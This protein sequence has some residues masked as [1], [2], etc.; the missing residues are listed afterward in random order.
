MLRMQ[1]GR[2]RIVSSLSGPWS[3]FG[4]AEFRLVPYGVVS[5]TKAA[6]R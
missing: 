4:C 2:R 1:K 6:F 3:V 5:L